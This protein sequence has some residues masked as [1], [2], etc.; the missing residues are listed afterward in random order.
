MLPRSLPFAPRSPLPV[1]AFCA[2]LSPS[3]SS[4]RGSSLLDQVCKFF[5]TLF[6]FWRDLWF[7]EGQLPEQKRQISLLSFLWPFIFF[8]LSGKWSDVRGIANAELI[9]RLACCT[10]DGVGTLLHAMFCLTHIFPFVDLNNQE[11]TAVT[12]MFVGRR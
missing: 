2:P 7:V 8:L 3:V 4:C 9:S 1:A 12:R 10:T 5:Q 11:Q 6:F